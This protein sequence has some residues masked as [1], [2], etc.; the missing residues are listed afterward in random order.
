[1]MQTTEQT[2]AGGVTGF[3]AVEWRR[4]A[5]PTCGELLARPEGAVRP[6]LA[7]FPVACGRGLTPHWQGRAVFW[8]QQAP[9]EG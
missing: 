8:A 1:M 3:A 5:C 4:P 9:G 7:A 2:P 6:T